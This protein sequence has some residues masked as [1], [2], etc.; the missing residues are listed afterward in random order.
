MRSKILILFTFEEL[1]NLEI[2]FVEELYQKHHIM[3]KKIAFKKLKDTYNAEEAVANTFMK[4]MKNAKKIYDFP[5]GKIEPYCIAMLNNEISNIYRNKSNHIE[6]DGIEGFELSDGELSTEEETLKI[7]QGEELVNL[8]E[9]LSEDEK[10]FL[11]LRYS[12]EMTYNQIGEIL[13]ISE[14]TANKRAER[15]HKKRRK[16]Y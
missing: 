4:I 14:N 16:I 3:L 12:K 6:V 1:S 13:N 8:I 7:L 9:K 15:I 11:Y 2:K 5:E 10:T